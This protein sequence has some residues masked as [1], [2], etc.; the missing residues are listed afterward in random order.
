M[1]KTG[2]I[3]ILNWTELDLP[4]QVPIIKLTDRETEVKVDI[5]FNVETGVKAARFIKEHLKV[6]YSAELCS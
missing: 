3:D 5:S 1:N 2:V 4:P 6:N